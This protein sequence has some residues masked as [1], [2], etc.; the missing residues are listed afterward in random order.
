M[1][2]WPQFSLSEIFLLGAFLLFPVL[3]W[4]FW[5]KT[6][7]GSEGLITSDEEESDQSAFSRE[8]SYADDEKTLFECLVVLRD[9]V[10]A[11][12]ERDRQESLKRGDVISV[13]K[14]PQRW[15]ETERSSYLIVKMELYGKEARALLEPFFQEEKKV[16][17][18]KLKIDLDRVAFK[19]SSVG[20]TQPFEKKVFG[21]EVIVEK[22]N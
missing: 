5:P 6:D 21:K 4:Y 11:D 2:Y 12:P 15:S 8:T 7:S 18:R 13:R 20:A 3:G 17:A 19:G 14:S 1:K 9:Q 22:Q 10:D 16:Q